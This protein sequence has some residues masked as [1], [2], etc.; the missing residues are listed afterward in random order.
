MGSEFPESL[1]LLSC[2][3]WEEGINR[4][5]SVGLLVESLIRNFGE[6]E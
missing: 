3:S 4:S 5:L 2:L 1:L 6:R